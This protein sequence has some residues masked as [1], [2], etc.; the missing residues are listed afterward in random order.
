MTM[1]DALMLVLVFA[2]GAGLGAMFFGGLWWTVSRLMLGRLSV[3]WLLL[4]AAARGGL[5]LTGFLIV[6][7]DQW[8]RWFAVLAGFIAVRIAISLLLRNSKTGLAD[9]VSA[10]SNSCAT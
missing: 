3:A 8:Q 1:H 7:G 5:V 9:A 4:S 2:A 6:A 10:G